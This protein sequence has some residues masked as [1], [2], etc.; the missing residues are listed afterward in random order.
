[1]SLTPKGVFILRISV[2]KPENDSIEEI[3]LIIQNNL[4]E[5]NLRNR[6]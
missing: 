5:V 3:V 1:M 4:G 2:P 6:I